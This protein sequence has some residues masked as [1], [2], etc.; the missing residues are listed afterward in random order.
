MARCPA[1]DA[2]LPAACNCTLAD[3]TSID[4]AGAGSSASPF[5]LTPIISG[6]AGNLVSCGANGLL[7][8]FPARVLS[9]P[10]ARVTTASDFSI[11]QAT[12][13]FIAYDS[14]IVD[15]DGFHSNAVNNTRLTNNLGVTAVFLVSVCVALSMNGMAVT[16]DWW[17]GIRKNGATMMDRKTHRVETISISGQT[18]VDR[19]SLDTE[20][21]LANTDYVESFV[22]QTSAAARTGV[23]QG[24]LAP[25]FSITY[26]GD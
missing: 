15:T 24:L 5:T 7:G 9:P 21:L 11:T 23:A 12:D 1:C 19:L 8:A 16:D 6:A 2:T 3:S 20:L 10:R 14:E 4:Q 13:V 17:M 25:I 26:L 22:R 18:S